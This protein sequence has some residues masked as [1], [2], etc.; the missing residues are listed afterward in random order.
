MTQT[1]VRGFD[2]VERR[3]LMFVLSSPSGAGK[4]TMSRMLLQ[5]MPNMRMSVSV[6]TRPIRPGEIDG[7]DY[8][9]VDKARFEA[10]AKDGEL[11]EWATVFDNRYGTPREP[12]ENALAAGHDVLFDIDWQG[13]QQ[14]HQKASSDVVRVFI[15]PPSA[16]D[17]EKR[18]HTRAQDS[19]E[20]IRGRMDRASHELSHWAEYDYIVVNQHVDEAFAEVRSILK[21]ERLKRERRT[22]LTEFVR[23]LQRQLE[24]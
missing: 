14:L 5:R 20:V 21:A 11:L 3:G 16:A 15:L 13:T 6:T 9:F 23:G 8:R 1:A 17:L 18:L 7:R 22:G 2:G 12:V 19:D 4:T 10:M 24:K